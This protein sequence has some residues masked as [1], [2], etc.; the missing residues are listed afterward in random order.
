MSTHVER[1]F[2]RVQHMLRIGVTTTPANRVNSDSI[3]E[4]D[5]TSFWVLSGCN[6]PS[7]WL[8]STRS[9]GL[10]VSSVSTKKR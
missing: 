4:A 9:S 2:R 1:V 6:W 3:C 8:I 7:S 5:D 10:M